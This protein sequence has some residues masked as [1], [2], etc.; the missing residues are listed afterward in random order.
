MLE[1]LL[2]RM[3]SPEEIRA[4]KKELDQEDSEISKAREEVKR[5]R[6]V[7]QHLC[8]HPNLRHGHD[9]DGSDYQICDDCGYLKE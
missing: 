9:I 5:K 4:A 3:P 1:E 2:R 6:K 7:L 8:S